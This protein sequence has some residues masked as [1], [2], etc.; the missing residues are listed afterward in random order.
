MYNGYMLEYIAILS[1][2]SVVLCYLNSWGAQMV[3]ELMH[4]GNIFGEWRFE[5]ARRAAFQVGITDFHEQAEPAFEK[6][7]E[8]RMNELNELYW[9]IATINKKFKLW[10]CP[11]CMAIRSNIYITCVQVGGLTAMYSWDWFFL[12]LFPVN[13][14][15]TY[16]FLQ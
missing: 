9:S 11:V 5:K 15:L 16:R 14:I 7:F 4:Y 8:S 2:S 10:L 3:N 1:G 12:A 13:S 6:D